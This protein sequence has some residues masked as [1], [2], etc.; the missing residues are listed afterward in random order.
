MKDEGHKGCGRRMKP[1]WLLHSLYILT[2]ISLNNSVH[3]YIQ[4]AQGLFQNDVVTSHRRKFEKCSNLI[5]SIASLLL[6]RIFITGQL[7]GGVCVCVYVRV[8]FLVSEGSSKCHLP[9]FTISVQNS[10]TKAYKE[11]NERTMTTRGLSL[12]LSLVH[13]I[14]EETLFDIYFLILWL[15]LSFSPSFR[16]TRF[17]T[18]RIQPCLLPSGTQNEWKAMKWPQSMTSFLELSIL[19]ESKHTRP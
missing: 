16:A 19:F 1:R 9:W 2:H 11:R 12:S 4:C 15:W 18:Q 7:T 8:P 6:E 17:T 14:I 3:Y 13:S 5:K 10:H